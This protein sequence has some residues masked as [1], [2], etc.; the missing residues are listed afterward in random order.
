[1]HSL[2]VNGKHL[3]YQEFGKGYPIL[4][5][6]SYLWSGSMWTPQIQAFSKQYHCIVPDL[7]G[8]GKS[9]AVPTSPYSIEDLAEVHYQLLNQLNIDHCAVVGLSVGGMWGTQLALNHPDR[10]SALVLMDTSVAPEPMENQ[11]RYR[12]LASTVEQQGKITEPIVEQILP[13]FFSPT[14]WQK[15]PD[16]VE[17]F[18]QQLLNFPSEQIPSLMELNRTIFSR[19]SLM[20]RLNE[21][22]M[23]TLVMVGEDDRSRPVDEAKTMAAAIPECEYQV[24]PKAGH[25]SNLEQ[26]EIVN[27]AIYNFFKNTSIS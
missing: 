26:P 18:K 12:H 4:F 1:M 20:E 14:T 24:I 3:A 11:Q 7:W 13:L 27:Q 17:Q 15:Q 22:E 16:L 23:P 6:H 25:I 21:L 19:P 9:E 2:L 8:H 10:V 5:G